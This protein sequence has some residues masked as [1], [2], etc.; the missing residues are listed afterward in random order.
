MQRHGTDS[1]SAYSSSPQRIH[2][3]HHREGMRKMALTDKDQDLGS[4]GPELREVLCRW[5]RKIEPK[6][7]AAVAQ[8]SS[9]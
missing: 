8:H 9:R 5:A 4:E 2:L 3:P 7:E 1:E 6:K